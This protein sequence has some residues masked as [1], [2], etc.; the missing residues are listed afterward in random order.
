[1]HFAAPLHLSP[2]VQPDT[3]AAR[4]VH[5]AVSLK[6]NYSPDDTTHIIKL[7][8]CTGTK[9]LS[10][11]AHF[12]Q[13]FPLLCIKPVTSGPHLRILNPFDWPVLTKLDMKK[14][15]EKVAFYSY[16]NFITDMT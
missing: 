12:F 16:S 11:F 4:T 15:F 3:S 1:M 7:E 5:V 6:K 10:K 2:F 9:F 13:F 8:V 14:S